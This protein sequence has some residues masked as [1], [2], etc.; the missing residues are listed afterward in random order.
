MCE[1]PR[2]TLH[3][4]CIDLRLFSGT[5]NPGNSRQLTTT[6]FQSDPEEKPGHGLGKVYIATQGCLPTTVSAFWRMVH[7]ENTRVIVMTTR[8]VERGRVGAQ[9]C[10]HV[11]IWT[12]AGGWPRLASSVF[13]KLWGL[14]RALESPCV[15]ACV[16]AGHRGKGAAGG[17]AAML[18]QSTPSQ[19]KCFRYWPELHGSQEYGCVHV[20][21]VAEYQSQGYCVRELQV[22]RPDQ[23]S[24]G[25][26]GT[27]EARVKVVR[28][29]PGL[30]WG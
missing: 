5:L 28:E 16:P 19:N 11:L 25:G 9:A 14:G 23:V 13:G 18:M 29:S 15:H 22:W 7:Q 6:P 1:P 10:P 17:L 30:R 8:E 12:C 21:N 2:V 20:C 26:N 3:I 27:C 4:I 24:L